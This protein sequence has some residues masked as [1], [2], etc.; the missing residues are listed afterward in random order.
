MLSARQGRRH[1]KGNRMNVLT[2]IDLL[3]FIARWL[4][5]R[6]IFHTNYAFTLPDNPKFMGPRDAV[7]RIP[8]G[9]ILAVSGLG[10][11][12]WA[13]IIYRTMRVLFQETGHPRNITVMVIG[14]QGARGRAPGSLEELGL[15]GLCTRL[16]AGHMETFKSILRL[17]DQGK[18]ELQCLPQGVLAF[19]IEAQ[20]RGE[21]SLLTETGLGTFLDPRVGTGTPV[22][23]TGTE[24]WVATEGDRLRYRLPKINVAVFNAPAADRKGNIYIKHCAMIGESMEIARAARRNGGL[25]IANVA[26]VVEEGYDEVFLPADAVDAVVVYPGTEQAAAVKHLR[27][28]PMFTLNSDVS[29]DEGI[30]RLKFINQTL[31]I[32]PRRSPVDYALARLAASQFAEN[33]KAG[34]LV[35]IGIGLPEEVCRLIHEAKGSNPVRF[36]SESGVLGGL[37]APGV[38]FGAGVCPEKILSSAQIF[39]LCYEHLDASILGM[40]EFDAAGNVNVSKRGDGALHYVGPGGFI[41]FSI[42]AKHVFFVASWMFGGDLALENGQVHIRKQGKIKLA[43]ALREITFNGRLALQRGQQISYITNVGVF[44]LT[45]RGLELARV[46]PGIDIR[47]DILEPTN[48]AVLTPESGEVP[49]ADDAIMTGNGFKLTLKQ[50]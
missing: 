4:A 44:K 42:N 45:T 7:K 32:T 30:A 21:D 48:H 38:F 17:A 46:V 8:D 43:R 14:G 34:S 2:K 10:G 39:H 24:Q 35:N 19:L 16:F 25:V 1:E 13:S 37:P 36:F 29:V 18:A 47:R 9:A 26:E 20:G 11:N 31:G 49:V 28:W 5:T 3:Y 12:Q 23:G 50:E 27:R 33:V 40:L 6:N 15:E 41:D 22:A